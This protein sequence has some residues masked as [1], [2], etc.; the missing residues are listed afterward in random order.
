MNILKSCPDATVTVNAKQVDE[1]LDMFK[2][3][4]KKEKVNLMI[5]PDTDINLNHPD[6]QP[7]VSKK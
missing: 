1:I 5:L 2:F 7:K 6:Y 4:H 3:N